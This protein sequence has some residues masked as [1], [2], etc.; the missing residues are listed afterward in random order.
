MYTG[1]W[2]LVT[3]H[4]LLVLLETQGTD[5]SRHQWGIPTIFLV[6]RGIGFIR[7]FWVTTAHLYRVLLTGWEIAGRNS[8]LRDS[9]Q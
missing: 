6:G 5:F 2:T 4:R 9:R 1:L 3:H 7:S 8:N